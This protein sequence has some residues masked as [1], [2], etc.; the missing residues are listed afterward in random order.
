[1]LHDLILPPRLTDEQVRTLGRE[2]PSGSSAPP[3][4]LLFAGLGLQA[5]ENVRC[6][7]EECPD[8][9]L[10]MWIWPDGVW[11][12]IPQLGDGESIEAVLLRCYAHMRDSVERNVL[13]HY[14]PAGQA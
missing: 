8:V 1:M 6:Y 4:P 13:T 9:H 2:Y 3:Y 12:P 10:G 7:A 14:P 5:L 11:A